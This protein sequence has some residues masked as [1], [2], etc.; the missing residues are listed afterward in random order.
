MNK[1]K[2][3]ESE[4]KVLCDKWQEDFGITVVIDIGGE[5]QVTGNL[6]PVCAKEALEGLIERDNLTH[7][8]HV[9]H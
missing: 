5:Y 1:L 9:V 3:L 7:F 2:Q 8:S 6:C 4:I